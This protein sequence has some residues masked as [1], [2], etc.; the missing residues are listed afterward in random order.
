MPAVFVFGWD[1]ESNSPSVSWREVSTGLCI[2]IECYK[3]KKQKTKKKQK[4][5]L[6]G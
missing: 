1:Q 3:I 2:G 5:K 6:C 4:L